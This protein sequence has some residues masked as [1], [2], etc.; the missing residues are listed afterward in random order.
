MSNHKLKLTLA[1]AAALLSGHTAAQEE[2]KKTTSTHAS[3][4]LPD[5]FAVLE[6]HVEAIGGQKAN[7]E[8]KGIQMLG[9]FDMPAMGIGGT[10]DIKMAEPN[11]RIMTI[12]VEGFG[13]INQGTDGKVA[14][15]T[16]M[17]GT[18]PTML[19]GEDAENQIE[20][21][22]FYARVKPREEY[23]SAETV[24][25]FTHDDVKVYKVKLVDSR[26]NHSEALYEIES[27]LLR[28]QS[29]KESEDA[30]SFTSETEFNDYRAIKDDVKMPFELVVIS[31]QMG[32]TITFEKI[33]IDPEFGEGD[34]DAP[35]SM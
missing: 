35:G 8:I 31:P 23:T 26:G 5:G 10:I 34:F 19:E 21:A 4:D 25:V 11:K 30:T 27:G 16:Q 12:N 20:D 9:S 14:W 18:P 2:E 28:K 7:M 24:G 32:Q 1:L 29:F 22:D 33:V 15:T 3:A 6:K 17:P 13:E